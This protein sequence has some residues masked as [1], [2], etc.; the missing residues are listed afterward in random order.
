MCDLLNHLSKRFLRLSADPYTYVI[1]ALPGVVYK[2]RFGATL[3]AFPVRQPIEFFVRQFFWA[4][5]DPYPWLCGALVR[6]D[7]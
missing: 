3:S 4:S 5:R 1:N 6:R 7:S 2:S